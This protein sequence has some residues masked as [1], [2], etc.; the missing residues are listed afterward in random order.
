MPKAKRT[1]P[2]KRKKRMMVFLILL[3]AQVGGVISSFHALMSTRTP[4]G[5]IAWIVSLNTFPV[6]ALPAYWIFGRNNFNGY[7]TA[8][9]ENDDDLVEVVKSL[10]EK[11][12]HAFIEPVHVPPTVRAAETLARLPILKGNR[13][14]LLVDG[15][16]T[17]DSILT[18][19]A[20]AES[21]VLVEFFIIKDDVIGGKLKEALM[22]KAREGVRVYLL[23]DEVGSSKLP[24]AYLRDLRDAGVEVNNFHTRKGPRNRFQINFRNHRKIVVVDGLT[25]WVG[26]HNVGDEYI[27]G[28]KAFASW[29]DTHVK[30]TGPATLALQLTFMEDWNWATDQLL[31]LDWE[32]GFARQGTQEV[33]VI[34]SGPADERETATLMFTHAINSAQERIWIASPYFVPDQGVLNALELAALRGVDVRIL[35]PDEP[36]H[37]PVYLAA[38]SYLNRLGKGVK[39]WRYTAGFMHQKV[40]L[41]DQS[42]AAVGT[43]NFDNRSFRLNFEITALVLDRDFNLQVEAMLLADFARSKEMDP[44]DLENKSIWFKLMSRAAVLA[45]PIL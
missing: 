31:T 41:L 8:R 27:D 28:G 15:Q 14:E 7:V 25:G 45:A 12:P 19:I 34:P 5:T 22:A 33:L 1:R 17:F 16:Q 4:Q 9:Q 36:D 21:Y 35:I 43:A 10:V 11:H 24:A 26:G 29:R 32:S 38:F 39:V 2:V 37:L 42:V 30:I 18:G 23:Y 40:V 3:A 13:V 20:A 6:L 44:T